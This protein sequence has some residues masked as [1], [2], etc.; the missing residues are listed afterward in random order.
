MARLA[1]LIGRYAP[2]AVIALGDSFHDPNGPARLA[3]GDRLQLHSLQRGRDWIW[4]TGNHDPAPAAGTAG[5][6]AATLAIGELVLRHRP[7]GADGE[8]AGHLH[9][10]ARVSGHG[11]T[12][13]RR[14][15]ACDGARMVMPAFGA[16]AGGLDVRDRAFT[17]VFGSRPFTAHMLGDRRLYAIP[18]RVNLA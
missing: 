10:V 8:I 13:H 4:L 5:S 7:T 17:K 3:A 14:C 9:P 2:R 16:Y 15:F 18:V 11:R 1:A 6:F 12:V